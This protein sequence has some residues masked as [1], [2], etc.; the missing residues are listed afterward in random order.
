MLAGIASSDQGAG[1][2]NNQLCCGQKIKAKLMPTSECSTENLLDE[3][4]ASATDIGSPSL[5]LPPRQAA[6]NP[7]S[8]TDDS[9][10]LV[11]RQIKMDEAVEHVKTSS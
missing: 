9:A 5:T 3:P 4:E 11:W 8:R 6:P 2:R 10:R 7:H 1:R